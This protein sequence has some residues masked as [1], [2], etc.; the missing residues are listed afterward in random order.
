[1]SY[2]E[3]RSNPIHTPTT[4]AEFGSVISKN[5]EAVLWAGGTY[6]MS[7]PNFY[8]TDEMVDIIDRESPVPTASSTSAR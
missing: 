3:L 1:M 6:L 5:P 2:A 7:R 4:L 8:P